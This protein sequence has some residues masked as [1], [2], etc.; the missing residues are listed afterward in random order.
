M[1]NNQTNN[2]QVS[3]DIHVTVQVDPS[4]LST[5]QLNQDLEK[6]KKAE[7]RLSPST[8]LVPNTSNIQDDSNTP[9]ELLALKLKNPFKGE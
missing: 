2:N 8:T 7:E 1:D 6:L 3:N 5:G 4:S 9:K